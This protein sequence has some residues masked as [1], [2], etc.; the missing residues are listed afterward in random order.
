MIK[1]YIFLC[2]LLLSMLFAGLITVVT[3]CSPDI[4]SYG[5]EY[6]LLRCQSVFL[7]NQFLG[8]DFSLTTGAS[9]FTGQEISLTEVSIGF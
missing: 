7:E 6:S 4:F 8:G 5:F 2:R 9:Q 1:L 3:S